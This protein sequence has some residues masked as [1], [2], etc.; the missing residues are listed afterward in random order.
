MFFKPCSHTEPLKS[1][2]GPINWLW[3]FW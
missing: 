1:T 3:S 2:W